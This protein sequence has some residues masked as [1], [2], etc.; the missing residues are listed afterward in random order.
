MFIKRNYDCFF[1][2][3]CE[4]NR[5]VCFGLLFAIL[6]WFFESFIHFYVFRNESFIKSFSMPV[7]HELW[8]RLLVVSMFILYGSYAQRLMNLR[9]QAEEKKDAVLDELEQ[10]FQTAGDGMRVVDKDFNVVRRSNAYLTLCGRLPET[11]WKQ[12]CYDEFP[13]PLCKTGACPLQRVMRGEKRLDVEVIKKRSDGSSVPCYEAVAPFYAN[14]GRLIGVVQ[15]FKDITVL[16]N[17]ENEIKSNQE[18]ALAFFKANPVPCYIWKKIDDDFFLENYNDSAYKMTQGKIADMVGARYS[19]LYKD[20]PLLIEDI[21]SCFED[22]KDIKKEI[23]YSFKSLSQEKDVVV[24]YSYIPPDS[25]LVHTEDV[26][27]R[28]EFERAIL[29]L[30]RFP[31]EDP[32]LILRLDHNSQLLYLNQA[33]SLLLEDQGWGRGDYLSI[34]PPHVDILIKVVLRLKIPLAD[35]EIQIGEKI[36]SY[37]MA[38]FSESGYVNFYGVDI[39]KRKLAENLLK[40]DKHL[41]EKTIIKREAQLSETSRQLE[42][43]KRFSDIGIL[44]TTIAHELRNPLGVIRSAVY[45]I[46]RKNSN[47]AL[48]SHL[49][50][51][52]KKVAESDQIIRNLLSYS[53]ISSPEY[54]R[55]SLGKIVKEC[56]HNC[57]EKYVKWDVDIRSE[58][59]DDIGEIEADS[60]HMMELFCNII[61]NAYQAFVHKKGII[62]I[63]GGYVQ[64]NDKVWIAI[65]DNGIGMEEEDLKNVFEPFFTKK[66]K[67]IGLGLTVCA[68]VVRLHGG[69]IEI[70]S[71]PLKGTIVIVTLPVHA[72]ASVG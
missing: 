56:A 49:V 26:T 36:F 13:G 6:F 11:G 67:G 70:K 50:N 23:H 38:P 52:E 57:H 43:A 58:G 24:T 60:V 7:H 65:E 42:D 55:L 18:R 33:A 62:R 16:K 72:Q 46:N 21:W 54:A 59:L 19:R 71:Q 35:F 17:Y 8:M 45:N 39:T 25:V 29:D 28:K 51:I 31:A 20:E 2:D 27:M 53:K 1:H 63:T 69:T 3:F 15:S 5:L 4:K 61:D 41:L 12:K 48:H 10:I 37:N 34:L 64:A 30:S 44:A 9:R 66:R 14:D 68:Q 40:S 32:N 47:Q 22:R